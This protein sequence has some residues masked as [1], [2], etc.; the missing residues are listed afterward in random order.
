[1]RTVADRPLGLFLSSGIDSSALACRLAAM[2]FNR[3]QSFTAAF[4][5]TPFDESAE[6]RVTARA[7]RL[8]QSRRRHSAGASPTTSRASS[9]TS[10]SR[11]PIRRSVP[12][13]Y[14]ARETT[15][16]VK[17]VLGGD[18][19][20]E[21]FGGYKRYAKHL[22]TRWRAP[23]GRCPHCRAPAAIG[24]R[25][26]QRLVEELRL[27]WRAA[28]ALRFSGLTP[29]ERAFLAPESAPPRA[30]LADAGRRRGTADLADAARDRPAELPARLHPAQGRPVHDGARARDARAVSRPPLR[31]GGAGAA[32]SASA[33]RR[34]RKKL[35][36]PALAPLADR[37]PFTRK[38]RGFNP[39]LAGWLEG[40][41]APRLP[42]LGARLA[43]LTGG[44]LAAA[45]VDA[46]VA[47][48][49]DGDAGLGEQVL[50]LVI[51]DESLAQ[52]GDARGR[53][54]PRLAAPGRVRWCSRSP[55]RGC[56]RRAARRGA[57]RCRRA[58]QRILIAHHLLLGDTIMLTPL[59]AKCRARWPDADIVMTCPV[60][61]APLYSGR[62]YGVR[63]V[64]L[65]SARRRRRSR[66]CAPPRRSI[67]RSCPPTTA[68]RGW[69]ARSARTGS[70]RSPATARATRTG[71]STSCART[72]DARWPGAISSPGSSTDRRPRRIGSPTGRRPRRAPVAGP[73]KS[74]CV[75]HAGA[76][77]PLKQWPAARW[78]A[79]GER[80]AAHGYAVVLSAGPGEAALLDADRSGAT[81]GRAIPGRYR[82]QR[83]GACSPAPRSSSA[84]IPASRT[85]RASSAPRRSRCSGPV[86]RCSRAPAT[87][88]RASPFTALTIPD[89]PCRDQRITMKR[90]VAWIRRCERFPG[91]GPGQCPEPSCMLALTDDMVWQAAA[92]HL[93]IAAG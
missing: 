20:D 29:G 66:H 91:L 84:P 69:R 77:T 31:R 35:L 18:G 25:G 86:R 12:T 26:W 89:F 60:P 78:R 5:G 50:Q 63:A 68:C 54:T 47:A 62:P 37:E 19:G 72:R 30:L 14:L 24:G 75:L 57:A 73:G 22:R 71:R 7:A 42:G 3:L 23:A 76:S 83:S 65:R 48:W 67:S 45:R 49:R 56:S 4:P 16:H 61:F 79:L 17:V 85:S 41:L 53:L 11:S 39:P 82:S 43:A 33:S 8:S 44:Q 38:K 32:G 10:T 9:P 93:G 6:A 58:P 1:M 55:R 70:S 74:Y 13:W 40:D 92:R 52:L 80:L 36:A 28:Y 15:R 59:L 90:E 81:R 46:F 51:L 2:G 34:R 64:A 88:W 87:F 21:L 27:D